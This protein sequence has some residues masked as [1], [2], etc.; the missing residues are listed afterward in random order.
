MVAMSENVRAGTH[1]YWLLP[2]GADRYEGGIR[3][4][5]FEAVVK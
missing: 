4:P 2:P 3:C 1:R 5:I